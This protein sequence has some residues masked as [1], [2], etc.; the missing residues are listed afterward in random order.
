ML[1]TNFTLAW[2]GSPLTSRV[3]AAARCVQLSMPRSRGRWHWHH[4][5]A[6]C[7][8]NLLALARLGAPVF[9]TD[10]EPCGGCS[11]KA[12]SRLLLH[13]IMCTIQINKQ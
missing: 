13:P 4:P 1:L 7:P 10:A 3:G 8:G 11:R 6:L 2:A 12:N 9:G 5:P